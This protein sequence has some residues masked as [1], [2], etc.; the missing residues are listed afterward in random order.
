ME[1]ALQWGLDC[2]RAIQAYASPPLTAAMRIITSLG[3]AV[4]YAVLIPLVCWCVDAKKGLRLGVAV[5]V[6]L[7]INTLLKLLLDQPRPFFEGYDPSVGMI[8]ER[9]GGFPSGHAQNSLVLWIIIASWGKR[10]WLTGLAALICLLV[11]FSRVYLGVHFPTDILGG[12][13]LGGAVLCAYFTLGPRLEAVIARGGFRAGMIASAAAAFVMILYRPNAQALMPGALLLGL[14]VGYCLNR[15]YIG[16]G[17]SAL[18]GT[19]GAAKY[20]IPP[21][22]FA[23]GFAGLWLLSAAFTKLDPQFRSWG[24]YYL[25]FFFRYA[26][27]ALWISAGAPWLFR[28]LRL[29][30]GT[31][32]N[33]D[34]SDN[35]A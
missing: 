13:L 4:A 32:E 7:W 11:S 1:D 18:L 21:A 3:S 20:L 9:L 2:I 33:T 15:R 19:G 10:K 25:F 27:L 35:A 17:G 12:W 6:S 28:C 16:G 34:A 29:T 14:G 8:P 5:L 23:L 24:N 31:A 22:R 30:G 26:V